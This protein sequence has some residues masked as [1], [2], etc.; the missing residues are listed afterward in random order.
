MQIN[1]EKSLDEGAYESNR[2]RNADLCMEHF[3]VL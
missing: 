2:S 1:F 3:F